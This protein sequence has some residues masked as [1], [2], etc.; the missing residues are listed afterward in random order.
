MKK[1]EWQKYLLLKCNSVY[2]QNSKRRA[3]GVLYGVPV[4]TVLTIIGTGQRLK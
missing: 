1:N 4:C 3:K 2:I